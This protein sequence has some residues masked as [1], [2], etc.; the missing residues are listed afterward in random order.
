[1]YRGFMKE[2]TCVAGAQ[3]NPMRRKKE[4]P[5]FNNVRG[6]KEKQKKGRGGGVK[7]RDLEHRVVKI[8]SLEVEK[9]TSRKIPLQK[10]EGKKLFS[11]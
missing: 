10:E 7:R 9:R 5:I 1:M 4:K 2:A 8:C 6:R 3:V 11:A